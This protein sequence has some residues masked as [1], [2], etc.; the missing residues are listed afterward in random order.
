MLQGGIRYAPLLRLLLLSSTSCLGGVADSTLSPY[1]C[2]AARKRGISVAQC[3]L[4]ISARF[5]TQIFFMLLFGRLMRNLGARKIYSI[6]VVMCCTFNIIFGTLDW[7]NNND[8]YFVLSF[9][10]V[11][12]ST[13]GDAGIFCSVYVLAAEENVFKNVLV[14]LLR[15]TSNYNIVKEDQIKIPP[16]LG[17]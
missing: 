9:I 13:V 16:L 6:G 14:M 7:V 1:Y 12:L 10:Y 8:L 4:V 11:I 3:G 2:P 17:Y 5:I 15:I